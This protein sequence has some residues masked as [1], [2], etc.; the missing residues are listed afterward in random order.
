MCF[1]TGFSI[2]V[3]I[4]VLF[5]C[6]CYLSLLWIVLIGW[7][8]INANKVYWRNGFQRGEHKERVFSH[9]DKH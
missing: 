4:D 2:M 3:E 8:F 9:K 1:F 6:A 7:L 5:F